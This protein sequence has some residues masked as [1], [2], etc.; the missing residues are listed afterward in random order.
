M[1]TTVETKNL[2]MIQGINEALRTKL[3]E[4]DQVL[5]LGQDVGVNGGVFRATE[6]L[7][8]QFGGERVIDT[9]LAESGIVGTSVGMAANGFRPVAEMQFLGFIYPAFNQIMTHVSRIRQ[10]SMG[11]Y[12]APMVIRAPFGAGVRAP[13]VHSDSVEALFT[14]MPGVKVVVPSNAY[15]AKGLLISAIEDPDPVIFLEPM[16]CYRSS[17]TEVPEEKYTVKLGKAAVRREGEDIS[18]F[19]WGAMTIETMKAVEQVEQEENITC[20]VID[21]RTLYPMDKEA[22]AASVQKTGR[23]L[24]VHEAPATGGVSSEVMAVINDT[25][26]LYLCS[27]VERVCGFDTPVPVYSLENE[28][29]PSPEKIKRA[30]RRSV[31]F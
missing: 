6:G 17:R 25:S 23:A 9:P 22:I 26:F 24:I 27:P 11:R 2:T 21:L 29:I 31:A 4:D 12:T 14:H 15:D 3:E 30:I 18:V 1:T 20:D 13:E 8:E 5:V 28:Y 16:R 7:H 10:R 19:T